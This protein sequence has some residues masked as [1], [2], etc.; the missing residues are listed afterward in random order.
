MDFLTQ[1]LSTCRERTAA[2]LPSSTAA[3][4]EALEALRAKPRSSELFVEA[5]LAHM[6]AKDEVFVSIARQRATL[7]ACELMNQ[8]VQ[9]WTGAG[10]NNVP[11]PTNS[12]DAKLRAAVYNAF[13]FYFKCVEYRAQQA[14]LHFPW[15][16]FVERYEAMWEVSLAESSGDVQLLRFN[17]AYDQLLRAVA[18]VC[19]V[20]RI[21][22]NQTKTSMQL[23]EEARQHMTAHPEECRAQVED[24]IS[25]FVRGAVL[26]CKRREMRDTAI[27]NS[28]APS[29]AGMRD[30]P[31]ENAETIAKAAEGGMAIH[32]KEVFTKR[33]LESWDRLPH[34]EQFEL[35]R[36]FYEVLGEKA[37][38]TLKEYFIAVVL[39]LT[40]LPSELAD[41]NFFEE[42][43][44][45]FT[46]Q[47]QAATKDA[48]SN[49]EMGKQQI[50]SLT[51]QTAVK[52][53]SSKAVQKLLKLFDSGA[54]EFNQQLA[55]RLLAENPEA[56]DMIP[57][58]YRGMF[59]S[60]AAASADP[61]AAPPQMPELPAEVSEAFNLATHSS[62]SSSSSSQPLPQPR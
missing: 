31:G 18:T 45:E 1:F 19:P 54:Y 30:W 15:K 51:Q 16:A 37:R 44:S 36:T 26:E 48:P 12:A 11:T 5:F 7:A 50:V 10:N 8:R 40:G 60:A 17:C 62:A 47:V 35:R 23:Y 55:M 58:E 33:A 3:F 27:A 39:A 24:I 4:D 52:L 53:I 20:E 28:T 34:M 61:F 38:T 46:S 41:P 43:K 59:D 22:P 21:D 14:A 42:L 25:R 6:F 29:D 56:K 49:G 9:Q 32:F 57:A 2:H 13:Y